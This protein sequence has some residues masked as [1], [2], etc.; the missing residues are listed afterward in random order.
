[1]ISKLVE[2]LKSIV[3][4][5]YVVTG[6]NID[7][8]YCKDTSGKHVSAP[9]A[10]VRPA[11][12]EEVAAIVKVAAAHGVSVTVVGGHTG[13]SGAAVA[14]DGA[15]VISLD[16][17][18][19]I[20]RIDPQSMTMTLEAG[21]IVQVA[22]EAAEAQGALL[23]LDLG[24][25]GSA[26]IGGVIGT[27]AG[28]N[29]VLRWGM[30]RDMVIGLE[31]VLADGTIISS[32][33][34]MLK[35]NAGY[36]WKHLLIGSEGTLAIVTKAVLRLRPLPTTRQTALVATEDF[37]SAVTVLRQLEVR[38]SGRLTSFELLWGNFYEAMTQAQLEQ[39]QRP[40]PSGY[41]FYAV[42]EAMGGDTE[43]DADQFER[44]LA[45]LIEGGTIVDAVIA[46]SERERDAIW[47][48]RE[49]FQPLLATMRP[50]A[51]YDVSMA[52]ADM[53]SFVGAASDAI[54]AKHPGS[55]ILFYGHAGDG[56]LHALVSN[57][58]MDKQIQLDFDTAVF[59]AVRDVGGSISA[60][61]G[62]G[63]LRAPFLSWSR[64]D[65]EIALMRTLKA[66]LDPDN[67]LNPG[68]VLL[69]AS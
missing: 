21:C 11:S 23:P 15:I 30:M 67:I 58:E 50:L 8:H 17:M 39:R 33:T 63:V 26:T 16:R 40:L 66:A 6:G 46:Q 43:T 48:I 12:S 34:G 54:E 5:R 69:P 55:T 42:L 19:R 3:D 61:H 22:Q 10:V 13:S 64:S 41:G 1:M 56:N 7:E 27:N 44:V 62:V 52:V 57:G 20:E 4:H 38:L 9:A 35:D 36:N 49:D 28:G 51:V 68:K 59:G 14:A 25:R 29:R 32:L 31:A 53:P 47:A 18:N 24:S 45:D 37:D 65:S 2:A 60:E